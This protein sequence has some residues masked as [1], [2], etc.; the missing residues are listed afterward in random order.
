MVF[1]MN[2]APTNGM[3]N[4]YVPFFAGIKMVCV[5]CLEKEKKTRFNAII[6]R[7]KIKWPLI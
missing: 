5:P 6:N 7:E 2:I 4:R 3:K 1:D